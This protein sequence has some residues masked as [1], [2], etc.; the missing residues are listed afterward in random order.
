MKTSFLRLSATVLFLSLVQATAQ[1]ENPTAPPNATVR[2]EIATTEALLPKLADRA[3]GQY[4]LATDYTAL[5]DSAKALALLKEA[6]H[7]DEGFDP[8][9]DRAFASLKTN[10]EFQALVKRAAQ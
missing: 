3:A 10:P 4:L 9:E 1:Q 6:V 8:S 5:G 7:S 2:A